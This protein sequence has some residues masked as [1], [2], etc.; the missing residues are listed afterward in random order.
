MCLCLFALTP[1]PSSPAQDV[2]ILPDWTMNRVAGETDTVRD[3]EGWRQFS[4]CLLVTLSDGSSSLEFSTKVHRGDA[5]CVVEE[6]DERVHSLGGRL[7][8]PNHLSTKIIEDW[9]SSCSKL[10]S[11]KC[12]TKRTQ[13][14]ADIKF[15][16]V[17]TREIVPRPQGSFDYLALSYVWGRVSQFLCLK[18][19]VDLLKEEGSLRTYSRQIPTVIQDAIQ[20]VSYIGE[21]YLWVDT[22]CK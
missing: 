21:S 17:S 13:E 7:I 20:F 12:C 5:L 22:L 1:S 16:D 9:L 18:K 15:I 19:N 11:S 14:L 10:H 2:L 4:K 3:M 6:D 8:A